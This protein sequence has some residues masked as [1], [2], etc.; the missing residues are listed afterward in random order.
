MRDVPAQQPNGLKG[1][2]VE[3]LLRRRLSATFDES[4]YGFSRLTGLLLAPLDVV[5]VERC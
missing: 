4:Q 1:A 5:T 3:P 2:Q